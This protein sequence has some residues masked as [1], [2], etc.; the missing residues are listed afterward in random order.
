[1]AS[2][3]TVASLLRRFRRRLDEP[4]DPDT[5]FWADSE[6]LEYVNEA[7]REVW[8]TIREAHEDRFVR[9]IRS[10]DGIVNIAGR[11]YD[12]SLLAVKANRGELVLPPDFHELLL[13]E[14]EPQTDGTVKQFTFEFARF[15][16]HGF[17]ENI[18]RVANP[19]SS[20]HYY[21]IE[22]RNGMAVIMLVP[23]PIVDMPLGTIIKYVQ[24]PQDMKKDQSFEDTGFEPFMLDAVLA[25]A[26]YLAYSKPEAVDTAA[27]Q[28]A[29]KAWEDKRTF[30]LRACG[31]RQ[32]RDAEVIEGVY[33]EEW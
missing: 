13:F 5:N 32:T 20:V 22:W 3:E 1:M 33:E 27:T 28:K 17:R 7:Q 31:P 23:A 6:L 9:T 16:M 25:Y 15:A 18:L 10:V 21:N 2:T 12:T 19:A 14:T 11:D 4:L 26:K 30:A 29:Y 24:A 8:Q